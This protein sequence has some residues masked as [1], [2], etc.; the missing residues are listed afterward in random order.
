MRKIEAFAIASLLLFRVSSALNALT[1]VSV[2][3]PVYSRPP[4]IYTG[5]NPTACSYIPYMVCDC[6]DATDFGGI[7]CLLNF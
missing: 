7:P 3:L 2:S 5:C 1:A 4:V 6:R